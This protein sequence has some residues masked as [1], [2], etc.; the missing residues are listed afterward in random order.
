MEDADLL[1]RTHIQTHLTGNGK[2]RERNKKKE[3]T[4]ALLHCPSHKMSVGSNLDRSLFLSLRSA[5]SITILSLQSCALQP[6]FSIS[7]HLSSAMPVI[8]NHTG[9]LLNHES[10]VI[11]RI[12]SFV[13]YVKE[14]DRRCRIGRALGTY[15]ASQ[16]AEG[17]LFYA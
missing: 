3:P 17:G 10:C 12:L 16:T 15:A 6:L 11:R 8:F 4:S 9:L 13:L 7:R 14:K 2:R 1:V 5:F